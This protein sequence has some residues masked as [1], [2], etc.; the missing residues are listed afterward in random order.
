MKD[1]DGSRVCIRRMAS[2]RMIVIR[3]VLEIFVIRV[4]R[5]EIICISADWRERTGVIGTGIASWGWITFSGLSPDI[6]RLEIL[7]FL[8]SILT[9]WKGWIKQFYLQFTE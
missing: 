6:S 1:I 4:L 8:A 2:V 7:I 9:W 5:M 3:L